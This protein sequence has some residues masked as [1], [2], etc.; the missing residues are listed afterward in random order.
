M[1]LWHF[2]NPWVLL[3]AGKNPARGRLSARLTGAL[4]SASLLLPACASVPPPPETTNA[5]MGPEAGWNVITNIQ[6]QTLQN[7]PLGRINDLV[8][9]LSNGRIVAVLVVSGQ[10]LG[11]GGK[12]IAVPPRA[13]FS[14][15]QAAVYHIDKTMAEFKSAPAFDLSK[16]AESTQPG[17]LAAAYHFFG[18]EPNFLVPGEDSGR[19]S[20]AGR[21][22]TSLGS[23]ERMT[24]L[25]DLAVDNLQGTMLG[26]FQSV[27][28]DITKGRILNTFISINEK[29]LRPLKYFAVV[30]P[31][32]LSFNA[33]HTALVL[34]VTKVEYSEE[35]HVIIK[36]GGS[37]QSISFHEQ[38]AT[39]P[40][41]EIPLEQGTSFRDVHITDQIYQSIQDDMP[42]DKDNVEVG[43][44]AGRVTLRGYVGNQDTKERIGALAIARVRLENV[45]NQIA[46]TPAQPLP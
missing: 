4:M 31:M 7:E 14:G 22:I 38:N 11:L 39:G 45:D 16:W 12:T 9:D 24:K 1:K 32:L 42:D 36:T 25:A 27:E 34:D 26:R 8:L 19:T 21:N 2:P 5:V 41:T 30:P 35:P 33:A 43:T 3:R 10:T 18:Q 17:R 37:G 23:V 44:M 13:L 46:V 29:S 15:A 40:H 20:A 6:I 28:V